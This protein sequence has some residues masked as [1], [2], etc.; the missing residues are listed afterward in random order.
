MSASEQDPSGD[1]R[2]LGRLALHYGLLTREQLEQ[3]VEHQAR[4]GE[5]RRLGEV[6][7]DLGFISPEKFAQLLAA[8]KKYLAK[9]ETESAAG[10]PTS[11][12][13]ESAT[14]VSPPAPAA[15]MVLDG[16]ALAEALLSMAVEQRASDVHL[17]AGLQPRVRLAGGL[18]EVP[19]GALDAGQVRAIARFL[20]R[21]EE[22]AVLERTGQ[23]DSAISIEGLGRFRGNVFRQQKGTDIV[24]RV[25]PA[26]PPTLAELGLPADLARLANFRQGVVLF[27]GPTGCGKT[28]T[29]AAMVRIIN[30]E[31]REHIITVEDPIEYLHAPQRCAV[32]QRQVGRDT[33]SFARALRGAL[34]EDPDVIVIGE[35]RDLETISLA[36]TAA[37]TGHLVFASMHTTNTIA[38][39]N[40]LV[41]VF[42]PDQQ[43]QIRMMVSES[44]RAVISQRLLPRADGAGRVPALEILYASKAIGNLIRE[45]KTFQIRSALQTGSAHGMCLLDSSL[46]TLLKQGVITRETARGAAD[47]PGKFK[48]AT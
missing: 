4:Y 21:D 28:S 18:L 46:E 43:Q 45:N 41:G 5:G 12:P 31:R 1:P 20:L 27:T 42:P 11:A 37:E 47:N 9:L 3:A 23:V 32:N 29:L 25:I 8:Q 34:R 35:L 30:E 19:F 40:R 48:E 33:G 39:V 16:K 24:L 44:L 15:A 2:L 10:A 7:I 14:A 13:A 36:L 6:F 22:M 38:T 17:H 26:A